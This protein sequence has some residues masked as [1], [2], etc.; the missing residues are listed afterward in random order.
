MNYET[1]IQRS[2]N[3]LK[4]DAAQKDPVALIDMDS[5]KAKLGLGIQIFLCGQ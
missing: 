1:E 3:Y 4:S 2:I 5:E